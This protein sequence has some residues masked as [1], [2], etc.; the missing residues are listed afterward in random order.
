MRKITALGLI[1]F[2][3]LALTACETDDTPEP[4]DTPITGA[5][6]SATKLLDLVN[7]QRQAGCRCGSTNMPPVAPLRWSDQLAQVAAAHSQDM[8][9]QNY[10][11]HTGR[12]GSSPG[13]RLTRAGYA[14][15]TYG[16]N[17][18]KGYANEEA[19]ISGWLNSEGHCKNIMNER[20]KEMG[21]GKNGDYW[22]QIFAT[23]R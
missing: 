11:S 15:Q 8:N 4:I 14:W 17:I 7:Q 19:V 9:R 10:F 6:I 23:P 12:D 1:C 22:T 20:F 3:L 13:D 2:A 16:E 18:A 5:T 21:V